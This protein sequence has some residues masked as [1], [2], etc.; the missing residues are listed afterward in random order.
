MSVT[1]A[2]TTRGTAVSGAGQLRLLA[3][4]ITKG[5]R[6]AG[7]RKGMIAVATGLNLMTYLGINLFIGGGHV[8]TDLMTLTMP[9]LLAVTLAQA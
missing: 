8:I 9:A 4:E 7:R 2:D 3:N 5:L 1:M 6:L